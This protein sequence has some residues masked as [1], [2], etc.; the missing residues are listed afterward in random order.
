MYGVTHTIEDKS[1]WRNS[2]AS[3]FNFISFGKVLYIINT[4]FDK[5]YRATRTWTDTFGFEL[6][7]FFYLNRVK[8]IEVCRMGFFPPDPDSDS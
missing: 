8:K 3:A 5:D 2:K 6:R 4:I 1:V 7:C